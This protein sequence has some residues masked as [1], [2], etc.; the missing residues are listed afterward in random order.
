MTTKYRQKLYKPEYARYAY[1]M[2]LLGATNE[3]IARALDIT[4]GAY[5][6]WQRKYPEF[7]EAIKTGKEV[8]DAKV[9]LTLY[10][11]ATGYSHKKQKVF[12]DAKTGNQTIVEYTESYPPDTPAMMFWLKNRRPD[13]WKDVRQHEVGK[14]G[15]FASLSDA[16]LREKAIATAESLGLRQMAHGLKQGQIPKFPTNKGSDKVN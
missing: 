2:C 16:E 13:Q 6:Y 1:E 12:C 10:Q 5:Q 15:D 11:K 4:Q 3:A 9:A 14:P 8:A 7:A